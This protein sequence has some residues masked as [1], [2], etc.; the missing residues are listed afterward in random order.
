MMVSS[1][2]CNLLFEIIPGWHLLE[3]KGDLEAS[4]AG[5]ALNSN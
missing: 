3:A 4:L 2:A 1:I 5:I